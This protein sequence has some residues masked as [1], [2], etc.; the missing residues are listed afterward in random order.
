ME[1]VSEADLKNEIAD[2]RERF[3]R[4]QDSDLF[5]AWF[6]KAYVTEKEQ[7]AIGA[8]VGGARD[9]SLDAVYV[10]DATKTVVLVQ[11]K[12]R[13]RFNGALEHRSDVT[14]FAQLGET[15]SDRNAFASYVQDLDAIARGKIETAVDRIRSRNYWL[16]LYYVTTGRCSSSLASE[17]DRM[18]RQAGVTM[19]VLDGKRV[20]RLLSDY[21]DGVAPPVPLLELEIETGHAVRLGGVLQRFDSAT[22][23]ESWGFPVNVRHI[24]QMY[25]QAGIRLFARNV[26]GFL[27]TSKINKDLEKTLDTEPEFFWYYNNGITI[28]CD[29]AERLSRAG[30]NMIRIVNPQVINGQQTT[31]ILHQHAARNSKATVLVR[32]ISVPRE[33]EEDASRF[34]NL[35][36]KIVAATNWQNAIRASDLMAND[37]TQIEIERNLRKFEYYY[38][39]KRESKGEARRRSGMR[40]AQFIKKDELAQAV[41]ACEL[42]PSV[43]RG[44]KEQLFE[45]RYYTHVF[46]DADPYFYLPRYWLVVH[47]SYRARGYPERAYAK[48][49]VAHF[50]WYRLDKIL[51][52]RRLK[53]VFA[54]GEFESFWSACDAA[55][56]AALAFYR[57]SRGTGAKALDVSTFFQ[58]RGLHNEFE[59][60]WNK[61]PPKYRK[62]FKRGLERFTRELHA[63]A[64]E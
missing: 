37:R 41:A 36:S 32:V 13:Q 48:W 7:D 53:D 8:L 25:D 10:D 35:V 49:L 38:V 46:P 42:D 9:K 52:S 23:I 28:I 19:Q 34:E 61:V 43:V 64:N 26:R 57:A 58:R 60:F 24:A 59:R 27:G 20:L 44:G 45:E 51:R 30:R 33:S 22:R 12:Y 21:L 56:K 17:A 14:A 11:G 63:K 16:Q 40:R 54:E 3:P 18:A 47:V 4:L 6:L 5:V 1:K 15:L 55:F 29:S 31:R 62:Q 50:V 39:R 2:M